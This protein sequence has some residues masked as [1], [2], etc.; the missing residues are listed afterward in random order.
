MVGGKRVFCILLRQMTLTKQHIKLLYGGKTVIF[1][2]DLFF[3][4]PSRTEIFQGNYVALLPDT[5]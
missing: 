5:R 4:R 3:I 1:P 2:S